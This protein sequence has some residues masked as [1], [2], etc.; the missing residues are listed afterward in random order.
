VTAPVLS[1]VLPIYDEALVIPQLLERLDALI[2]SLPFASE[3]I[4]VD[5]GSRDDSSAQLEAHCASHP[6]YKLI[7]FSRNFG[8]QFAITAGV[9]YASG[10]AV[11]VMDADL[12]DPPEIVRE[13]VEKWRAGFDVVYAVRRRRKGE[14]LFKRATAAAFYRIL[15]ALVGVPIPLDAGD[16]RLMGRNVVVTLRQLRECNRFVRGMVAWVGFKQTAIEYDRAGRFAGETHYTLRKMMRLAIDAMTSFSTIPLR[17]SSWLGLFGALASVG[18][19]VWAL[20]VNWLGHV[21]PGWTTVVATVAG[22]SSVQLIMIGVLG[23][24]VG[25]IYEETKQRPLYI[26]AREINVA[27]EVSGAPRSAPTPLPRES[28]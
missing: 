26:V 24:Y 22:A 1:L 9:D 8:H 18:I 28:S 17:I 2:A 16:F 3:V 13:M 21:V 4:F 5:D 25:R 7:S 6:Q 11:V 15:R 14:S 10:E 20:M 19:A 27:R 12:Q 23:E